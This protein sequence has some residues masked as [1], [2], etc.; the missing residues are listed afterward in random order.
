LQKKS[1]HKNY[2]SSIYKMR[3]WHII[4]KGRIRNCK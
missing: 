1:Y 3:Q 2:F 4:E